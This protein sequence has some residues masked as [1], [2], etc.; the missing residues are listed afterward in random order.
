MIWRKLIVKEF[1]LLFVKIKLLHLQLVLQLLQHLVQPH[2]VHLLSVHPS[3]AITTLTLQ[4]VAEL[5]QMKREGT[6]GAQ[7]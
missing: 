5:E 3:S 2:Y 6:A 7:Q 1:V 4:A